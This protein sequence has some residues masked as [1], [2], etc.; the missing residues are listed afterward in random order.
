MVG[1]STVWHRNGEVLRTGS[2]EG[3]NPVPGAQLEETMGNILGGRGCSSSL[4]L[5]LM[6]IKAGKAQSWHNAEKR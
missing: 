1:V 6:E 5:W 4:P 3:T 2:K